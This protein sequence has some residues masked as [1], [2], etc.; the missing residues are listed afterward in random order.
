MAHAARD[1]EKYVSPGYFGIGIVGC[2]IGVN[3][4]TLWRSAYN[5]GAAFLVM[6]AP[7][8]HKAHRL[9]LRRQAS[10]TVNARLYIPFF[11]YE[12]IEQFL[13]VRPYDCPLIVV[14]Q[15]PESRPLETFTHPGRA[16]YLLGAEDTGVPQGV[17]ERCTYVVSIQTPM[18]LNVSVAGSIVMYDR[19][20]KQI[21]KTQR[22][23]TIAARS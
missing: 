22:V 5:F 1:M 17:M 4:G 14:E 11:T 3:V 8:Y 2:K 16:L 10:D 9:S 7:R 19:Q 13:E 23:D 6:I 20:M 18:C 12:T 15:T 21:K